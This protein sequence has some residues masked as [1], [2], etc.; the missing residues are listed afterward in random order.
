MRR[1]DF[2]RRVAVT[3]LGGTVATAGAAATGRHRVRGLDGEALAHH[4]VDVVD[5][6]AFEVVLRERIDQEADAGDGEHLVI[7]GRRVD[8]HAE[9]GAATGAAAAAGED[10]QALRLACRGIGEG[11]GGR[12]IVGRTDNEEGWRRRDRR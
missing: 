6:G 8:G 12:W 7:L 9:G 10:A 1:P 2:S 4:V 5:R 3:G 11:F